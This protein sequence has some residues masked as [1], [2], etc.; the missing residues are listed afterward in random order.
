MKTTR[1]THCITSFFIVLLISVVFL[2][3]KKEEVQT[4][5]LT[6]EPDPSIPP[7]D[8]A[9]DTT[10]QPIEIFGSPDSINPNSNWR[11]RF[12]NSTPDDY[13]DFAFIEEPVTGVYHLT[14]SLAGSS[15]AEIHLIGN[16]WFRFTTKN[17]GDKLYVENTPTQ[18]TLIFCSARLYE[19][20]GT[21]YITILDRKYVY[22]K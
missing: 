4:P 21:G 16:N 15:C 17:V 14:D 11:I 9:I 19:I 13:V 5:S 1:T 18:M 3:C 2:S 8:P 20:Y 12:S 7:C 10:F 22:Y 6:E